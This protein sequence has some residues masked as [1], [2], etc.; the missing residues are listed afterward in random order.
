MRNKFDCYHDA[1]PNEP[2]FTLLARDLSAPT[3]IEQ[4]AM[5]RQKDILAG[6]RPRT[7]QAKVDEAMKVA[8]NMRKWR[9]ENDG[10]WRLP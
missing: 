7:D 9:I 8:V 6:N 5:R 10:K 2:T 1:L 4:W 3:L